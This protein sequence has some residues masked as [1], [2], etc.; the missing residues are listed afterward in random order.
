MFFLHA[1]CVE[2]NGYYGCWFDEG[3]HL[4]VEA[5][6]AGGGGAWDATEDFFGGVCG[7][8]DE[9]VWAGAVHEA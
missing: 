6:Y 4:F 1:F 3:G 7:A 8:E 9:A 5:G 2:A